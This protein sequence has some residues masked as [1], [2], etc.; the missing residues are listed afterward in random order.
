[1]IARLAAFRR[2]V[3]LAR[4]GRTQLWRI[5]VGVGRDRGVLAASTVGALP[6]R[7]LAQ[8]FV[9]ARHARRGPAGV[10][11]FM[12]SAAGV[13]AA[14]ASFVGMSIGIF[15]AVRVVHGRPLGSVLGASGRLAW[16]DFRARA[17]PPR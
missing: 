7:H 10:A 4:N 17:S 11:D 5:V 16:G 1:M 9:G 14:L 6:G 3:A 15:F 2:Y 12:N 8:R 13:A